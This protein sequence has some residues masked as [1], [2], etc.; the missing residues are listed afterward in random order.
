MKTNRQVDHLKREVERLKHVHEVTL[1]ELNDT[2]TLGLAAM[3]ERN[4]LREE[5]NVAGN[6]ES[7]QREDKNA[8]L[9]AVAREYHLHALRAAE[10]REFLYHYGV[11]VGEPHRPTHDTQYGDTQ[12]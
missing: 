8:V 4:R 10:L 12:P 9:E 3:E 1:K 5:L 7:S 6:N 11:Q 2:V